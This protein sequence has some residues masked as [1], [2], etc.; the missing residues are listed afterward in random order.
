MIF[1]PQ[2]LKTHYILKRKWLLN[3]LSWHKGSHYHTFAVLCAPRT[4][5]TLLHTCLN[6]HPE[7]ISY[8]EIL[9]I[10]LSQ[11][12][13]KP[14]A[15]V[16]EWLFKP[17]PRQITAIGLK[18]FYRYEKEEDFRNAFQ[19]VL[20]DSDVKIIHLRRLDLRKMFASLKIAEATGVWN[21][22]KIPK[23]EGLLPLTVSA[24]EFHTYCQNYI[25]AWHQGN[26]LFQQHEI[27][28]LSYEDLTQKS[29]LVLKKVQDFLGVKPKQLFS[30][31]KKQNPEPLHELIS[32]HEEISEIFTS[33]YQNWELK[34]K[35]Q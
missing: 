25:K 6:S 28:H 21:D 35:K 11:Q 34:E 27:L 16:K 32:N 29:D 18:L 2:R 4:G 10:R 23:K 19:E 33:Y 30:L 31:L 1:S 13:G 3:K 8:G 24:E 7:V 22:L 12:A 14:L 17:H 9:R 15:P 5:S 26:S 20:E